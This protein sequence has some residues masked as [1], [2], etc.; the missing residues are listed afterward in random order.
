MCAVDARICMHVHSTFDYTIRLLLLFF[1]LIRNKNYP[2]DVE[3][4]LNFHGRM[5]A[6]FYAESEDGKNWTK[7]V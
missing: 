2:K 3:K 5:G 6:T 1:F 4:T 7:P